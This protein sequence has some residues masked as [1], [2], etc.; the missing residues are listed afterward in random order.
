MNRFIT[1]DNQQLTSNDIPTIGAAVAYVTTWF[2]D[3]K[4]GYE[5]QQAINLKNRALLQQ[6]LADRIAL[7]K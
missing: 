6:R 4:L 2:G 7:M 5:A 1:I 3:Q